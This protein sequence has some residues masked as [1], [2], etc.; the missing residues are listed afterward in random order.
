[1]TL[2]MDNFHVDITAMG[3]EGFKLAMHIAALSWPEATHWRVDE[4]K[5]MV[6][7]WTAPNHNLAQ[8]LPYKMK[9][10]QLIDFVWNWLVQ[11]DYG[12]QPDH[13]GSNSKGWRVYNESWGHVNGEWQTYIAIKPVWAMHGK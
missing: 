11:A 12:H 3:R 7:Y 9:G 10:E 5:G 6:L 2:A 4:E 13:D 8:P 1:M